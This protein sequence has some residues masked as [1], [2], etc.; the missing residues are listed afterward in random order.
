MDAVSVATLMPLVRGEIEGLDQRMAGGKVV[1][2]K[3]Y[4][5]G[6]E[7]NCKEVHYHTYHI[8]DGVNRIPF[9]VVWKTTITIVFS[10]LAERERE[11]ERDHSL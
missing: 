8:V 4:S 5:T 1:N 11:R 7:L 9:V 6:G 10:P 2:Q 3:K